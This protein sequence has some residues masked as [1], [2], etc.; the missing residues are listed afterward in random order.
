MY[1]TR[2]VCYSFK[3]QHEVGVTHQKYSSNIIEHV[4]KDTFEI[5]AMLDAQLL[6]VDVSVVVKMEKS[7]IV[8]SLNS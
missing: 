2:V 8:L 5:S 7:Y 6:S 4:L 1:Y 3:P